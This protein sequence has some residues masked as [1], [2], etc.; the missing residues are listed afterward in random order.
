[1][2]HVM[3]YSEIEL[4]SR[5]RYGSRIHTVDLRTKGDR[6]SSTAL[7]VHAIVSDSRKELVDRD[8]R[9]VRLRLEMAMMPSMFSKHRCFRRYIVASI[10]GICIDS[11]KPS[12]RF[13]MDLKSRIS[14]RFIFRTLTDL[15]NKFLPSFRT[16]IRLT[17]ELP[18]VNIS[19]IICSINFV[20]RYII[21]LL[22]SSFYFSKDDKYYDKR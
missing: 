9:V 21:N 18:T 1:M 16:T 6:L 5:R 19:L 22:G 8:T 10:T 3:S 14:H 17:L 15:R 20:V 2:A 4:R 11:S 7:F 13:S 12:T